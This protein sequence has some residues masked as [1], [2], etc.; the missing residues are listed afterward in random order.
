MG[1]L[2]AVQVHARVPGAAYA[3]KCH[4]A[5]CNVEIS[6]RERE[7]SNCSGGGSGGVL[8]TMAWVAQPST[9]VWQL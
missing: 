2:Q 6:V 1:S 3:H 8:G 4:A 7:C 9:R 5:A